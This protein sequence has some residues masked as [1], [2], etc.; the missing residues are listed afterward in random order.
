MTYGNKNKIAYEFKESK[1]KTKLEGVI[2]QLIWIAMYYGTEN[3]KFQ[4]L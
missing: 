1:I 3:H 4:E 2:K